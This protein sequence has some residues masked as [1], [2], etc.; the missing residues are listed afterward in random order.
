LGLQK[1]NFIGITKTWWDS[2]TRAGVL[3]RMNT[4]SSS[5]QTRWS[6]AFYMQEQLRGME[7]LLY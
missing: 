4:V 5:G 3:Q 2:L 6:S 7:K 1:Y